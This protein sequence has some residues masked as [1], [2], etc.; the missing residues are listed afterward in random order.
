MSGL[1]GLDGKLQELLHDLGDGKLEDK[2]RNQLEIDP[3][4][5]DRIPGIKLSVRI[6]FTGRRIAQKTRPAS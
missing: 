2:L 4:R 1:T 6:L 5:Y 3:K